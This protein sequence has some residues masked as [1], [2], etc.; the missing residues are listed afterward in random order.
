MEN[1]VIATVPPHK[2]AVLENIKDVN[3][4]SILRTMNCYL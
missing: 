4:K 2:N 1:K 3:I